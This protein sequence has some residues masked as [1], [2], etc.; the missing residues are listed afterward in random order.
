MVARI[1]GEEFLVAMPDTTED[2]A[3]AAAQRLCRLIEA[4]PIPLPPPAQGTVHQTVSIGLAV[5][6]GA[7]REPMEGEDG[8]ET[9]LEALIDL[10]DR[11]LLSSKAH[12]RN[13]VT[14]G[15]DAA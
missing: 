8:T 2:E 5:G 13:M 9:L 15:R 10:A 7:T 1:G 11:A 4:Q 3:R 14:L 6:G 12:G